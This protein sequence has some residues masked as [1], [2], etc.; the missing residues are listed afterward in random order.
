MPGVVRISYFFILRLRPRS[1]DLMIL[2]HL[3]RLSA[4]FV[5][6]IR[7]GHPNAPHLTAAGCR[8]C[9]V[10]RARPP[11]SG[12]MR[13]RRFH[14]SPS[15][16]PANTVP[17]STVDGFAC[18][19]RWLT[20]SSKRYFL[21]RHDTRESTVCKSRPG[22]VIERVLVPTDHPYHLQAVVSTDSPL[23]FADDTPKSA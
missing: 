6:E 9:R 20:W 1:S 2:G 5:P 16:A 13:L 23:P 8:L 10:C 4:A 14:Q 15:L 18:Q 11:G 21:P 17:I 7:L 12:P 22:Q 19:P 3:H